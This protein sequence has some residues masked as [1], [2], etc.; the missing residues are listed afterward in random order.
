MSYDH[1]SLL[2]C[3]GSIPVSS[4]QYTKREESITWIALP[5]VAVNSFLDPFNTE[6]RRRP[7][8]LAVARE[9]PA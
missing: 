9:A 3:P 2:A 6:I 4:Q 5:R 7:R 1:S 8:V